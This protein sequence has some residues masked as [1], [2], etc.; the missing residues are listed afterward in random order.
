MT[1]RLYRSR[2]AS[3]V[4]SNRKVI[5][6]S[7]APRYYVD[8]ENPIGQQSTSRV[9]S[10]ESTPLQRL[11]IALYFEFL[12]RPISAAITRVTEA[13]VRFVRNTSDVLQTTNRAHY[14][15]I[16]PSKYILYIIK[17]NFRRGERERT[18]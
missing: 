6:V 10:T 9:Q 3:M 7:I 4:L 17:L 13:F 11:L 15:R 2:L 1:R 8:V 12:K 18:G 5:L 14:E 16:L